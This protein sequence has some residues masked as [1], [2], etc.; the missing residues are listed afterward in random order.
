MRIFYSFL[1]FIYLPLILL[2][3]NPLPV[4]FIENKGQIH[5]QNFISNQEVFFMYA[6]KDQKIQLRRNGYS[7]ELSEAENIPFIKPGQKT[8]HSPYEWKKAR[9]LLHRVD[10]DFVN[11]NSNI[12]V[13]AEEVNAPVLNYVWNGKEIYGIKSY[14]KITYKNVYNHINIEFI[15][16]DNGSF[17]YNIILFPGAKLSDVAFDIKGSDRLALDEAGNLVIATSIGNIKENIPFSFYTDKPQVNQAVQFQ[18]NG[19]RVNFKANVDDSKT[20][21][22]DP[23]SNLI[24]SNYIGGPALDYQT[25]VCIDASDNVYVGGYTF[26]SSNIA[27]SGVYQTTLSGSFDSYLVKTDA[28]GNV[29][30]GTYFGGTNVD[31]VY[32]LA[33]DGA[34][35]IY[36]GGD[37]FSTSNIASAGAHQTVYGGGVDDCM[38][39]KFSPA[40]QRI[41][42]TYYGGLEHDII[43]SLTVDSNGN[44]IITGH[45]DSNNAIATPGAYSTIYATGY[46]VFVT[47]FNS[48]GVLQWGTYYGDTGID[49][50]WGIDCDE[51]NNIYVTGFTSSVFGIVAGTPHQGTFGGGSNDAFLAKFNPAGSNLLWAT[52]FGGNGEDAATSLEYDQIGKIIITGNTNSTV[53]IAT[54]ASHQ[55]VIASAEDGYLAAFNLN[56][57]QQWGTYF[58]GEEADY[59][60]DLFID[61]NHELL[62]C[63]QTASSASISTTGAFQSSISTQFV[64]DAFF[65]KFKNNGTQ[66]LG[67]YF[68]G[69]ETETSKGIVLD[70]QGK[71]YLAGESTSSVNIATASSSYSVYSGAQDA[72]LAKFCIVSETP[73]NPSGTA[74]VC[75]GGSLTISA[76]PGYQS[77]QWSNNATTHS[78]SVDYTVSPGTFLYYVTVVD[79]DG[80]DGASDTLQVIVSECTTAL[81]D[82]ETNQL[83]H[84]FPN[85]ASDLIFVEPATHKTYDLILQDIQGREIQRYNKQ[86]GKQ[87]L[88]IESLQRGVYILEYNESENKHRFK[89]IKN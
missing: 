14:K 76:P 19:H 72:F 88:S 69:P 83:I 67:T 31:V 30:W 41:W 16:Q 23:S 49:E 38:L 2:S 73:L 68:G 13:S 25:S 50:G 28:T 44:V 7:Y 4:G 52:Y 37:T 1:M 40:G 74:T 17:K 3:G 85:P 42:S 48:S 29:L 20:F 21:I 63:G 43:G 82:L 11:A 51:Q 27:T 36:A 61:A 84:V 9:L 32:S 24:W 64:Y 5:D 15:I 35:N 45:T 47:K 59:V 70:S 18:L 34:G 56:G 80:C 60:Y 81:N 71:V 77:Y 66:V 8:T 26:S 33:A 10:V 46:D 75:L 22:I 78:I 58:G 62:F 65:T 53:N 89:I 79:A 57:V 6:G 39:F 54:S 86:K 87:L 12:S 55:S